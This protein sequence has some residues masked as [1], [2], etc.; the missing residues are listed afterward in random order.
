[1]IELIMVLVVLSIVIGLGMLFF[2]KA[3][4]GSIQEKAEDVCDLSSSV[5]LSSALAMP[6]MQC[7][8][9]THT[10]D[11]VDTI[12][13]LEF[14]DFS[15]SR[16]YSY[17]F[18]SNCRQ[19]VS[20]QVIYPEPSASGEC[21]DTTYPDNCNTWTIYTPS[22]F[23]SDFALYSTPASLYYPLEDEYRVGRLIVEVEM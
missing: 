15:S 4:I 14:K 11:C 22:D 8:F 10:K 21:T 18:S 3:N 2:F 7:S 13:L 23:S 16:D 12:K 9:N 1:M 6:E 19:R 20:F 17:H 5:L